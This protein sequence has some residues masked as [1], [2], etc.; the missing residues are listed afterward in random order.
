MKNYA[1]TLAQM[2]IADLM[3]QLAQATLMNKYGSHSDQIVM[4]RRE[5]AGRVN[6]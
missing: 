3:D 2:D 5:I 6:R 1:E 4:V